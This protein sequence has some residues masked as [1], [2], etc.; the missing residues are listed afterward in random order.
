MVRY[1]FASYKLLKLIYN[2]SCAEYFV[3]QYFRCRSFN[4][5]YL[6]MVLCVA[7]K[8]LRLL[9]LKLNLPV[10]KQCREI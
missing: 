2:K 6:D 4:T 10:N 5:S 7:K 9:V 8:R 3:I 1:I